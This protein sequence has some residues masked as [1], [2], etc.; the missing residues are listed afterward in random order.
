MHAA[1]SNAATAVALALHGMRSIPSGGRCEFCRVMCWTKEGRKV[2]H[3]VEIA[4]SIWWDPRCFDLEKGAPRCCPGGA[5]AGARAG[6]ARE[7]RRAS[8]TAGNIVKR[9]ISSGEK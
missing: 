6:G 2:L 8:A 9:S 3:T 4:Y 1:E 7:G 5:F